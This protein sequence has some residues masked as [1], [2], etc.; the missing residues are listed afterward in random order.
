MDNLLLRGNFKGSMGL[1]EKS[2][3]IGNSI[4]PSLDFKIVNSSE[5]APLIVGKQHHFM[6]Q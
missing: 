2:M 4:V 1:L 3:V 6:C 5:A